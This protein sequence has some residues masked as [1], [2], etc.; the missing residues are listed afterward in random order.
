M[1][2][3]SN[4]LQIREDTC[5]ASGLS[6][7]RDGGGLIVP[8]TS[9]HLRASF[10]RVSSRRMAALDHCPKSCCG[11]PENEIWAVHQAPEV[12]LGD[13]GRGGAGDSALVA[14]L[15]TKHCHSE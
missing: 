7:L 12:M 2:V 5:L 8:F 3:I 14:L 6:S 13:T 15:N 1:D 11:G 9:G 4:T 10:I